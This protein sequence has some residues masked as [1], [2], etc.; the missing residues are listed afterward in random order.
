M[1]K[2][3]LD[4]ETLNA[5]D[6][7]GKLLNNFG[8]EYFRKTKMYGGQTIFFNECFRFSSTGSRM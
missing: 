3:T 8:F 7:T 1:H 5:L 4:S 2:L 6:Q